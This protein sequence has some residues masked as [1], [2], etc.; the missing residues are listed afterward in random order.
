MEIVKDYPFDN[1]IGGRA[2]LRAYFLAAISY[3]NVHRAE[4]TAVARHVFDRTHPASLGFPLT[5]TQETIRFEF[6][7]LEAPGTPNIPGETQTSFEDACWNRL[8]RMVK[9]SD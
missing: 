3:R 9:Q 5:R 8:R 7:A 4:S 6:G 1:I 2:T